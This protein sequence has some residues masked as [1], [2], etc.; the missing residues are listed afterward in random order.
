MGAMRYSFLRA[1]GKDARLVFTKRV[2]EPIKTTT[3]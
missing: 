1:I 3:L 2:S